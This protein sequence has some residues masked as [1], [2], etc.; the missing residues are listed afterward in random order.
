MTVSP[1][2]LSLESLTLPLEDLGEH[3][4]IYNQLMTTYPGGDPFDQGYIDQAVAALIEKR[5]IERCLGTLRTAKVRT[6]ERDFERARDDDVSRC[7]ELFTQRS[8]WAMRDMTRTAAGCRWCLK[9]WMELDLKLK[10]DGT[11]YAIDKYASIML[12]GLSAR[13]DLLCLS[14]VAYTTWVDCLVCTPDPKQEEVAKVLDPAHIPKGLR[15]RDVTLWPGNP[16]ESRARLQAIVDRE[17]PRLRALEE[18]LRVQ[19]EVPERAEARQMALARISREE[20]TLLRAARM[21]EQSYE[22]ATTALQKARKAR[23]AAGPPKR[24]RRNAA[25]IRP[26]L[27]RPQ[28]EPPGPD[29]APRERTRDGPVGA[30]NRVSRPRPRPERRSHCGAA[31]WFT[32]REGARQDRPGQR[33]WY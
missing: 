26:I 15:D 20:M 30:S 21:A 17:L 1:L 5:R 27:V 33:P 6:A 14:E 13:L 28:P 22:R 9:F 11:W 25:A 8:E 29:F 18:T 3:Q 19:Y 32:G 16:A 7:K 31:V 23:A 10:A 4:R 12:Q 2:G 24:Y